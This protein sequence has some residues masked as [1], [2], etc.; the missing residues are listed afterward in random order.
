[1]EES[2]ESLK[3]MKLELLLRSR[4]GSY[5][6]LS[7]GKRWTGV[8]FPIYVGLLL[9]WAFSLTALLLKLT[10]KTK[11]DICWRVS[12][13]AG[14]LLGLWRHWRGFVLFWCIGALQYLN[15]KFRNRL[16]GTCL[17]F[18]TP[19]ELKR[20]LLSRGTVIRNICKDCSFALP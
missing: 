5:L 19:L 20:E 1:M 12:Y 8:E 18:P 2:P 7:S 11:S 13:Q 4:L 9:R 3:V 14:R 6:F 15:E 16:D 10:S 17:Q